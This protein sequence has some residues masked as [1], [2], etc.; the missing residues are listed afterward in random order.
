MRYQAYLEDR[1]APQRQAQVD[2]PETV[3]DLNDLTDEQIEQIYKGTVRENA[4]SAR[5]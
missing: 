2:E 5:R 3:E 4:R 1:P